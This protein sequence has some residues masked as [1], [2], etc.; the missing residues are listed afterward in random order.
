MRTEIFNNVVDACVIAKSR[1]N[2]KSLGSK[3]IALLVIEF[4]EYNN[5][6]I[7]CKTL[8]VTGSRRGYIVS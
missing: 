8:D 6:Q 2:F 3:N 1:V 5:Y 7:K 4:P